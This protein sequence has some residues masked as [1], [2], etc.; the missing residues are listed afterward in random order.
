M[1]LL[2]IHASPRRGGNT[3]I[4]LGRA[5]D[6]ARDAG[7]EVSLLRAA[8][9]SIPGCRGC[10]ACE[11]TGEC[12]LP[13]AMQ[14]VYPRLDRA[15]RIILAAPVYF[16]GFPSQGKALIDRAQARWSRRMLEKSPE[17]RKRYDRGKGYLIAV[18]ATRGKRLFEG[19]RLTARFFFD[20]LDM[21]YDGELLLDGIDARGAVRDHPDALD[22]AYALGRQ[23]GGVPGDQH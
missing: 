8:A 13:D 5:L 12:A 11:Q 6:G 17:Q 18:G 10:G 21:A 14:E 16:Y 9:L 7:A 4:L 23:A 1:N 3:E 20:A 19:M 2:G 15:D 22:R